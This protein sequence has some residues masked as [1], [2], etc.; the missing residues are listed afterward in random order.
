VDRLH[1]HHRRHGRLLIA[2]TMSLTTG[3]QSQCASRFAS[4][5]HLDLKARLDK[6]DVMAAMVVTDA[7]A[8]V[9]VRKDLSD[10]LV[11]PAH[12]G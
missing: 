8:A 2:A 12:R 5:A 4:H 11:Q 7:M 1:L 6:T 3:R 10:H 9:L